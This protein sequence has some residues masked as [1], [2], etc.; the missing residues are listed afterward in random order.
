MW[1][2]AIHGDQRHQPALSKSSPFAQTLCHPTKHRKQA[3][4]ILRPNSMSSDEASEASAHDSTTTQGRARLY[5]CTRKGKSVIWPPHGTPSLLLV[6]YDTPFRPPQNF[7]VPNRTA[8]Q[9]APP[10]ARSRRRRR[11]AKQSRRRAGD[12]TAVRHESRVVSSR[13][14]RAPSPLPLRRADP[15]V[16]CVFWFRGVCAGVSIGVTGDAAWLGCVDVCIEGI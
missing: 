12:P 15:R 13:R 8:S 6:L 10:P 14:F 3:H 16:V 1:F 4:T 5:T 7:P 2:P 9:P 11:R